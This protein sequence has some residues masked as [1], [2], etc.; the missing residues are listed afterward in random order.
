MKKIKTSKSA[1]VKLIVLALTTGALAFSLS[2]C[3]GGGGENPLDSL[4][5]TLQAQGRPAN[6]VITG[7]VGDTL[8][9][10]FFDWTVKSVTTAEVLTDSDGD[11]TTPL[12][13]GN[14]FVI[15]D[16]QAKNITKD[17]QPMGSSDFYIMYTLNGETVEDVPYSEFMDGMYADWEQL[18]AGSSLSGKVVF[19]I[20]PTATNVM[21]CYSELYEDNFEGDT[22]LFE[23]TL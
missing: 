23:V 15:V 5:K 10:S 6:N 21:I 19:E 16:T 9:N 11:E 14:I 7:K 13:E 12:T 22:Y 1:L 3:G 20:P 17:T 8:T 2:A 4:A 18:S